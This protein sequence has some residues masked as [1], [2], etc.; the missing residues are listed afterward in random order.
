MR[1]DWNRVAVLT[2]FQ[3]QSSF[4]L[5]LYA[6]E[7]LD[8]ALFYQCPCGL[9][10]VSNEALGFLRMKVFIRVKI[11]NALGGGVNGFC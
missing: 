10:L 11:G 5:S 8:A 7:S 9:S 3:D 2:R 6:V 4:K 1:K